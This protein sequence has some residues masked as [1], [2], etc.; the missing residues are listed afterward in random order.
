MIGSPAGLALYNPSAA[1]VVSADASMDGLGGLLMQKQHNGE[2]QPISFISR[3]LMPTGQR[4]SQIEK[5]AI[6]LTWACEHFA[7]YLVGMT[8]ELSITN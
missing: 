6:P 8:H 7:E 5:E 3:S 4:Y 2:W 1:T